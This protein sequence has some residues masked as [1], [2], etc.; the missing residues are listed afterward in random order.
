M[1]A[2]KAQIEKELA[3]S[4]ERERLLEAKLDDTRELLKRVKGDR[5]ALDQRLAEVSP[6]A[7]RQAFV[8]RVQPVN[9]FVATITGKGRFEDEIW[10]EVIGDT[11][12]ILTGRKARERWCGDE[13]AVASA[14]AYNPAPPPQ[15]QGGESSYF[16]PPAESPIG[17]G[18][19]NPRLNA[20]ESARLAAGDM[21]VLQTLE[22]MATRIAGGDTN[23]A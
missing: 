22:S 8:K 10:I 18:A 14:V 12:V 1:P 6:A 20:E 15:Q 11:L 21:S 23:I 2:T 17:L 4:R 9:G 19:H 3:E 5:D 7:D 13:G 16:G